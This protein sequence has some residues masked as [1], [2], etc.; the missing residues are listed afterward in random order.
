VGISLCTYDRLDELSRSILEE[1]LAYA[2]GGE[3]C[4]ILASDMAAISGVL[5][6]VPR[7]APPSLNDSTFL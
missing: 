1:N 5:G 4:V 3:I 2:E 6:T 7:R